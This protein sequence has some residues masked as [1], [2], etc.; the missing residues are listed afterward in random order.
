LSDSRLYSSIISLRA[1]VREGGVP[2][3][4]YA[5]FSRKAGAGETKTVPVIDG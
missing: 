1:G 2:F 4:V 3:E 5:G